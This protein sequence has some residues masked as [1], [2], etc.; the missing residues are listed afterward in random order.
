MGG[1]D[2]IGTTQ[3]IIREYNYFALYLYIDTCYTFV[4]SNKIG[5]SICHNLNYIYLGKMF[6]KLCLPVVANVPL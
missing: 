1:K 6:F 4:Q 3:G 5:D 2:K